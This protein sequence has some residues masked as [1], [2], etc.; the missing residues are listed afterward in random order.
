M[1]VS[2]EAQLRKHKRIATGLFFLMALIY[3]V[4]VYLQHRSPESWMGYVEAFSEAGMVGAL[5]DWFA[6]TALFRHP[7]GIPIPHTNLIERKQKD[8]GENLGTF[9]KDNFLNPENIRP[10]IEKLDVINIV[11]NWLS[12]QHNQKI[13]EDETLLLLKK[14]ILDLDDK[15]VEDFLNTK[16]VELLRSIDYQKFASSGI[17]YIIEKEEHLKLLDRV[18]PQLSEYVSESR[19]MIR[20]R[21]SENRPFIAFLAGK[22]I[23]SEV[24]DGLLAFIE[25]IQMD[26]DHFVR[27]KLTV[28][29]EEFAKDL[30]I[31]PKWNQKFDDLK[32]EFISE[33]NLASYTQEAWQSIKTILL[34]NLDESESLLK[35]YLRKNIQKLSFN[36]TNDQKM[37]KR[38]NNWIRH[39]LYRMVLKNRNEVERL[40]SNTVESWEG[41][42]LSNKLELE[43]GKDLQYIRINGTLV[44]GLVGLVIYSITHFVFWL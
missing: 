44:G 38:I 18:L 26:K 42:D 37:G 17:H 19:A 36:L 29:L 10:Y 13:L 6:V 25:E 27:Q 23:S 28:N 3:A 35:D 21:I 8:L 34:E 30:L 14:I 31:D 16:G 41:K 33:E 5:A 40:I 11:S 7:L 24:T 2:K 12:K 32:Q 22:K 4:M 9:V 39:F 20:Q 15:E 1:S 43:V